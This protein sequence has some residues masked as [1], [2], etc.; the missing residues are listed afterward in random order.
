MKRQK[1]ELKKLKEWKPD[2]NVFQECLI[3]RTLPAP[4]AVPISPEA[5]SLPVIR[6]FYFANFLRAI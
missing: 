6:F 4:T 3:N 5:G 2:P 1:T